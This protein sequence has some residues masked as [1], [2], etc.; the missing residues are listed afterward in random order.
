MF[1]GDCGKEPRF[2]QVVGRTLLRTRPDESSVTHSTYST[3]RTRALKGAA[4]WPHALWAVCSR[5]LW[6]LVSI[7]SASLVAEEM[8][9][10]GGF[11]SARLRHERAG[12][13]GDG[14]RWEPLRDG[15]R[16][17][18]MIDDGTENGR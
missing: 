10:D 1:T 15:R 3:V 6:R 14:R 11:E 9:M 8:D 4:P 7:F 2:P 12:D 5:P 16:G 17:V 18:L 13:G